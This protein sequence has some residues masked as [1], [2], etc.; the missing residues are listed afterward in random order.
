MGPSML[1]S[2]P[3]RHTR[4]RRLV[5]TDFTSRHVRTMRPRIRE[6]ADELLN[7]MAP[8]GRADLVESLA[9]P[10]PTAVICDLLGVPAEDREQFCG[11]SAQIVTA[12]SVEAGAAA[13]EALTGYLSDLVDAKRH[14]DAG[15]DLLS[16]LTRT[17][18]DDG[19]RLA[20][21]ELLGNAHIPPGP[22]P[23]P[24]SASAWKRRRW[25]RR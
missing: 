11:W 25:R 7:A 18:D 22:S 19:D 14:S 4:L 12:P 17:V 6:V 16:A 24:G 3:P 9:L 5:A 20:P 13:G 10:L 21:D 23:R 15:G 1:H 2:A 8:H